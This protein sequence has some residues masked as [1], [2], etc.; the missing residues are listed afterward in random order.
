MHERPPH[1]GSLFQGLLN[2]DT[3]SLGGSVCENKGPVTSDNSG[4]IPQIEV[5]NNNGVK[6]VVQFNDFCQPIR[7]GG[8]I[9]VQF[10]GSIAKEERFCPL[11]EK[12][13]REVLHPSSTVDKVW[14]NYKHDLKKR[15][16][17]PDE[18]SITE[19]V[20]NP[21]NGV[22]KSNWV[23]LVNYWNSER[24]KELSEIRKEARASLNQIHNYGGTSFANRRADYEDEHGEE[25]SLF[26]LWKKCYRRKDGTFYEGTDTEDFLEDVKA[27]VESLRLAYPDGSKSRI[28]IENEAFEATL[29]G[30]Q[31]PEKPQG[32]CFGVRSGDIYGVRGALRKEG[33]GKGN[34][35]VEL[36]NMS[37]EVSSLKEENKELHKQNEEIKGK[38]D[39]NTKLLKTMTTLFSQV[40]ESIRSGEGSSQL[41]DTAQ[42]ALR[43]ANPQVSNDS[44]DHGGGRYES[45]DA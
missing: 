21:P 10:L 7:K 19:I 29:Y 30:G 5:W 13:W 40:L 26:E 41:L 39:E 18:K 16:F 24:G 32:L 31:I 45:R 33:I 35:V 20:D 6:Y 9:L 1:N 25:M 17:K 14:R 4:P 37:S 8:H 27:K 34:R 23:N 44:V 28:E 38:C 2:Q 43:M 11:S 3:R 12:T 42:L 22:S 15:Y 36:G